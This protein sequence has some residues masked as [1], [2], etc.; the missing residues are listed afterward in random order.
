MTILTA[1][2]RKPFEYQKIAKLS[3]FDRRFSMDLYLQG[4][5]A[6]IWVSTLELLIIWSRG[7]RFSFS[8][9][10]LLQ[11]RNPKTRQPLES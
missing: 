11:L 9:E 10:H 4:S 1:P 6:C 7:Q 8:N 2:T 5:S 3:M